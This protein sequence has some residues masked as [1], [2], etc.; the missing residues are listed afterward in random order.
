MKIRCLVV[1]DE[2]LP[3]ELLESFIRKFPQLKLVGQFRQPLK[4]LEFL[5]H[6]AVDLL[7]L[8]IQLP[9]LTGVGMLQLIK[10]PPMVIF[11]TAYS[12][13]ALQSYELNVVDYLLK[14][15]T[16]SRFTSAVQKATELME[17]KRSVKNQ[18]SASACITLHTNRKV[19][20][21]NLS[22]IL[23]IQ[24]LKEYVTFVTIDDR[25]VV[26]E[27]LK[28]LEK[29][30]PSDQFQRVHKSYIVAMDKVQTLE[31]KWLGIGHTQIPIGRTYRETVLDRLKEA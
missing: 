2:Q 20:R 21:L 29:R 19:F 26:L 13:Y 15:F 5:Q 1:E 9:Q 17:L 23:Y 28:D 25:I 22:D 11:T 24:G 8:D 16:F 14:P 18:P 7:F 6:T 27:A 3:R 30:L 12:K 4:A 31:G 10:K